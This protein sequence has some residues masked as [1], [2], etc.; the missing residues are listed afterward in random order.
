M[1]F[2]YI[3]HTKPSAAALL[4]LMSF[5]DRQG[6]PEKLIR[7]QPEASLNPD[8]ELSDDSSAGETSEYD[9]D[10]EFEDSITT[11]RDYS[12]IS[13]SDYQRE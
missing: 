8:S 4:S 7:H 2:D 13:I 9:V 6:I 1:S 12:F 3:R 11:L 10:P 5:F